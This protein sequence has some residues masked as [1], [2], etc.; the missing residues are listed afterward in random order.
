MNDTRPALHK[1]AKLF[2]DAAQPYAAENARLAALGRDAAQLDTPMPRAELAPGIWL[3]YQDGSGVVTTVGPAEDGEGL[4]I[5]LADRGSS[6]WYSLSYELP[7][8]ILRTARYLGHFVRSASR[9]P[10]RF[11]LCLRY[12]LADGFRDSFC[13]EVITLTGHEQE[14]LVFIR[15]DPDLLEHAL[16]AE[17]LFF[18][19]G[20]GFDVT[21]KTVEVVHV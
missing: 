13:R 18:F 10:A 17:A 4:R 8:E 15:L 20:R 1:I 11:R 7:I 3:D 12:K 2:D 19:E 14:D 21:L 9:G 16:A 5:Q 6:P